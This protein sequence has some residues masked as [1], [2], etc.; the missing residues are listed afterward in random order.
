M[1]K[2]DESYVHFNFGPIGWKPPKS[3]KKLSVQE[4]REKANRW[5]DDAEREI[6]LI[7]QG[8]GKWPES[9]VHGRMESLRYMGGFS[10]NLDV[11]EVQ[12]GTCEERLE[13]VEQRLK[14]YRAEV[15]ANVDPC[16]VDSA[17]MKHGICSWWLLLGAF[18]CV[19]LAL[20]DFRAVWIYDLSKWAICGLCVY[21]GFRSWKGGSRRLLVPL[22]IMSVIFNPFAPIRF[23][24]AWKAVDA[25]A[26]ATFLGIF[27][28]DAGWI[29][30]GWKNRKKI[31]FYAFMG[32]LGCFTVSIFAGAYFDSKN[33]GPE[34]RAADLKE[35]KEK[36]D[37]AR[38]ERMMKSVLGDDYQEKISRKIHADWEVE[39][40]IS[41]AP[42]IPQSAPTFYDPVKAGHSLESFGQDAN[43]YPGK[44]S[45]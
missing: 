18:W 6:A 2:P 35:Q 38:H 25:L 23:G 30:K 37:A 26:S 19:V 40:P 24:A 8:I 41:R 1:N 4:K 9:T 10:L 31:G 14:S 20:T 43:W 12:S 44:T 36:A 32:A 15:N 27:L 45:K 5:I 42:T 34:R 29:E 11:P 3:G 39:H 33:G 13:Y 17:G 22:V 28:W 16:E 7:R 21:A